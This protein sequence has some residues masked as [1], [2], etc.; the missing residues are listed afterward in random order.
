MADIENQYQEYDFYN[1]LN[2]PLEVNNTSNN[3]P[4]NEQMDQNDFENNLLLG[5]NSNLNALLSNLK[6]RSE[7]TDKTRYNSLN[8]SFKSPIKPTSSNFSNLD[9]VDAYNFL[10]ESNTKRKYSYFSLNNSKTLNSNNNNNKERS[11]TYVKKK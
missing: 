10:V 6:G 5:V 11:N 8:S 4:D 3:Y 7:S 2:M 9:L 1:N